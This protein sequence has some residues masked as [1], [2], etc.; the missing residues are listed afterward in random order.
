MFCM[1]VHMIR[2]FYGRQSDQFSNMSFCIDNECQNTLSVWSNLSRCSIVPD[3]YFQILNV[4]FMAISQSEWNSVK[5]LV[6]EQYTLP[7]HLNSFKISVKNHGS[8]E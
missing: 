5:I 6:A 8:I 1:T 3:V 2:F 7:I 4:H